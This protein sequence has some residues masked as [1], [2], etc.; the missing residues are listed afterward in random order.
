MKKE[1]LSINSCDKTAQ[2]GILWLPEDQPKALLQITHGMTEHMGRYVRLA[3]ELTAQG[4]AVAGLD[5]R[6]HGT[7]PGDPKCASFGEDGW[8]A[9]LEDMHIFYEFLEQRFPGCPHFMFG[10][11]LGSFLLREY[12]NRYQDKIAGAAI[13]GTGFQPKPIL[14]VMMA[15]TKTQFK[16]AGFDRTTALVRKLSFETYNQ[17]FAPNRTVSDWLCADNVELDSYLSDPLCR[18]DISAGL[19]FQLLG[20]MKRTADSSAYENWNKSVPILL[21]SGQDDPV[22]NFGKGVEKVKHAMDNAGLK[23]VKMHLF[24]GAR[25]DLLHEESNGSAKQARQILRDWILEIIE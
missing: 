25:H 19:F 18:E 24:S 5:L 23:S 11:S 2:Q 13:L 15:V 1:I 4:I 7:N 3:E 14:S 17:K 6:G 9:S 20:A 16:K 10:F 22:G 12:L 8:E 21:L